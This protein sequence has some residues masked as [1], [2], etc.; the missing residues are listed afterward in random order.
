[1]KYYFPYTLAVDGDLLH[2]FCCS[3][4]QALEQRQ[5]QLQCYRHFFKDA[6]RSIVVF[7]I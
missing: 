1:M 7:A 4:C 3:I 5:T 2:F 6:F